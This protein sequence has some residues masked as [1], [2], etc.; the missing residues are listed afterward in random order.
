MDLTFT[1]QLQQFI[2]NHTIM[3]FAWVA[4][5]VA[6]LFNFYKG[7]TSKFKIVDN[8]QATQLVNKEEAIFLDVRS[9]DEFKAG[10][11]VNS[12][13][14]HPTDIKSG[15][16]AHIEKLQSHPVII[17]DSNGFTANGLAD[18]LAKHGFSKVYVLKE[19]ILGWRAANLPT[20]KK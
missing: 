17:V 18:Q 11:I 14:I 12:V 20:V 16:I 10:H 5:F 1:E 3:S 4:A 2:A 7:A 19:G 13:S 9:D 6:V 15:K 8:A